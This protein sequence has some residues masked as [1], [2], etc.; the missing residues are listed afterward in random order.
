MTFNLRMLGAL[1]AIGGFGLLAGCELP[2]MESRQTGHR[3]TS[4]VQIDNPRLVAA[5]AAKVAIPPP[6]YPLEVDPTEERAGTFY[7]NVKALADIPTSEFNR[8]MISITEWIVPED[9]RNDPNSGGGCNYCHNPENLAEDSVYT[10]VVARRMIQMTRNINQNWT[11]HVAATG[12]TCWTCHRGQAVPNNVWAAQAEEQHAYATIGWRN[13][14]NRPAREIATASLPVDPF[15]SY[16]LGAEE[17]RNASTASLRSDYA[18]PIQQT[19]RTYGLMMHFSS[20]LGVNCTFCHNTQNFAGWADATPQRVTAWHGI[21]MVREA[22]SEYVQTLAEIFPANRQGPAG[23]PWKIGC[24]TCHQGQ[25]KPLDGVSMLPDHPALG[26][27]REIPAPAPVEAA[28]DGA[29]ATPAP[30]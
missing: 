3:G 18:R 7:Q 4:M 8:L 27:V 13:G 22:N 2:P 12:V 9:V 28:A 10:K 30:G 17:I 15:S 1:A 24:A 29:A 19:E 21:R 25:N 6:P 26:P 20:S 14:Q 23:D 5:I 11:S 16:L